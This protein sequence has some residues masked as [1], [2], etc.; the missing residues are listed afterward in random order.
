MRQILDAT[1]R[2]CRARCLIATG[3]LVT[4]CTTGPAVTTGARPAEAH[5]TAP[6]AAPVPTGFDSVRA[7]SFFAEAAELCGR[8]GGR[9]W[10]V[11]LCGPMV[12]ADPVTRS[13][14]TNQPAP[15]APR[16]AALGYAN[17]A[18]KWGETR[19]T[20]LVWQHVA[21]AADDQRRVLLAHELFH[22]VQPELGFFLPEPSN[23]HLD[24]FAGR[25]WLQLEWRALAE[26]LKQPRDAGLAALRDAFAFRAARYRE[27][28]AAAENERVLMVNE[29]LA[30]Y[31]GTVVASAGPAEAAAS[32]VK[33]L[34]AGA[35]KESYVRT[36]A[37]SS[38]AAYGVLLDASSPGWTR[39]FSGTD[40]P[41][42]LLM[43]AT[44]IQPASLPVAAE[45]AARYQG[46]ALR[47]AEE[48]RETERA[49]R[50]AEFRRRFVEGPVLVLRKGNSASFGT[51]GMMPIPG[52]GVIYPRYRT[53][54]AWGSL[55]GD[56]VLVGDTLL[57]VPAPADVEGTSLHGDG[58]T[59][60]LSPDWMVR[61][62][63]RAGDFT[64]VRRPAATGNR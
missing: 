54:T 17:S 49:A 26:A 5:P 27:L 37:Y 2:E 18:M 33:Q 41:A 7:A 32:A 8:E 46:E 19:W 62:G 24:T 61:P 60:E 59:L 47:V 44:K 14:A 50:L 56:P 58:W 35:G 30:Q 22:R 12:I 57:R 42:L 53:T 25:Y 48:K 21:G 4:A 9:L 63:P 36:F 1:P 15:D 34:A 64:V 45:A 51:D 11:S 6:V 55:A 40:D 29:G 39:R 43:A 13:I 10:G 38:G 31:T 16:P 3:V 23:D 28:P 52:E 20:T